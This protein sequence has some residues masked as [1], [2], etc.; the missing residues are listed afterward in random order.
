[1][2][3][4]KL[5]LSLV[6]FLIVSVMFSFSLNFVS[7]TESEPVTTSAEASNAAVTSN[8]QEAS[9]DES[10]DEDNSKANIEEV[11]GDLYLFDNNI[12]M[13][14]YVDGS[15][16]IFG[17]KVKV[18][19]QVNGN[20]F[21]FADSVEFDNCYVRSSIFV[22]AKDVV[23]NGYSNDL[24]VACNKLQMTYES[25]VIRDVKAT[26]SEAI[27]KAAIGRDLDLAANTVDF[28][29]NALK[30]SS[31]ES[32]ENESNESNENKSTD[33]SPIIYGNLRYS[34]KKS[35]DL[36]DGI[37]EGEVT[38]KKASAT[39]GVKI[40]EIIIYL[41]KA[42][43]TAIVVFLLLSKFASN[44]V[45]ELSN[46]SWKNVLLALGIGLIS[47]LAV[48]IASSILVLTKVGAILGI[49]LMFILVLLA[50]VS[51]SIVDIYVA[52]LICNLAKLD[53][54]LYEYLI[55]AG[56][57][58]LIAALKYIP[59][60]G[61]ILSLLIIALGIGLLIYTLYKMKKNK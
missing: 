34:A 56:I 32:S 29:T 33:D 5:K 23:Y 10:Q 7:A 30:N 45:Q 39:S 14:K 37:V 61:S 19:G 1:M 16:F 25:Y 17:K 50:L 6:A 53:K 22:C 2:L 44:F 4:K 28:G 12:E 31:N 38:Y 58:L 8:D 24:Y 35:L 49:V 13:N 48:T 46:K 3:K 18:T 54:K 21:I 51:T 47:I 43:V 27:I 60:A 52:K 36:R 42:A 26:S 55:L 57:A 20:L 59:Y 41:L 11:S 9:T 40:S 15:V